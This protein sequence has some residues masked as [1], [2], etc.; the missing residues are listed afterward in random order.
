MSDWYVPASD[1]LIALYS[2]RAIVGGFT[3]K[4]FADYWS[5]SQGKGPDGGVAIDA[6]AGDFATGTGM[7][8]NK[9]GLKRVRL[10]RAF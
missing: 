8:A 1:E 5:S 10:I 2:N 6:L 3:T 7:A 4:G 9:S